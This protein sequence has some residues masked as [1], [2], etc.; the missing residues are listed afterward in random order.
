MKSKDQKYKEAVERSMR[1]FGSHKVK[2]YYKFIKEYKP[3]RPLYLIEDDIL[4]EVKHMLGIRQSDTS[5][6][7]EIITCITIVRS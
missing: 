7:K 4:Q 2:K 6:D 3:T 5:Q 1:G